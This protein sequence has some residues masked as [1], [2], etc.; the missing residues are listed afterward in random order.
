ME[1]QETEE[2]KGSVYV[3]TLP[4][5]IFITGATYWTWKADQEKLP[6]WEFTFIMGSCDLRAHIFSF[7]QKAKEVW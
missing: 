5:C 7:A 6:R 1:P 4:C 3:K 2:S